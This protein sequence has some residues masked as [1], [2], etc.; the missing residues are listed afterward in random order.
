MIRVRFAPSPTGELH[1]GGAR[2]AL[3]NYFFAKQQGGKFIIRIEDTDQ[4][5]LVAGSLDRLLQGLAWLGLSWDEGPDIGGPHGPYIQSQR[6]DIYQQYL[7][8]LLA[9]GAAY[10]CFCSAERLTTLRAEQEARR[11]ATRYDRHCANLSAA[12]VSELLA[13]KNPYTV[14]LKVPAGQTTITDIV[15]GQVTVNNDTLD[16]QI[17]LKS[18]GYPTYHLANVVDDHLMEIS[19]VIRGEEWLPSTPKH[20]L[21]YQAF[22]WPEPIW[23]HLPNVLNDKRSKLSKRR[24]GETVWLQTY[25]RQ[26]YLPQALVNFL[27]LLGWHPSDDQELFSLTE[28]VKNF[29]LNRVQKA[30]AIF[31]LQKLN[32]FN[33][34]YIKKLPL[35]ELDTWLQPYYQSLNS[36]AADTAKLTELL[37]TRLTTLAEAPQHVGWWFKTSLELTPEL[38]IP[39]KGTTAK[40][41]A[42]LAASAGA[43]VSLEDWQ[44]SSLKTSLDKIVTTGDF[45]RGE[46]LWP[47]RL[48]LTGERQSPDVFEVAWALGKNETIKRLDY[49]QKIMKQS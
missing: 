27:A 47:L 30:G 37:R 4:E 13:Q 31:S 6:L 26:G 11:E 43:L 20:S 19:H 2:T 25:Q 15:R 40:T 17:L 29:D 34:E 3:Y 9:K 8:E 12:E 45:T 14:R 5:R 22:G 33:A 32:W 23:A 44:V 49:A 36:A 28:L 10:Y 41:K 24:D 21:L 39:N 48:A 35:A 18:D 16:D 38:L 42:A 7:K 1:I 46:L